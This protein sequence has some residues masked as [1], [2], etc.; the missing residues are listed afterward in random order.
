MAE[1]KRRKPRTAESSSAVGMDIRVPPHNLEMERALLCS[2][3]IDPDGFARV[4]DVVDPG[5]FYDRRHQLIFAA[6]SRLFTAA[7]PIDILTVSE[8]LAGGE[9]LDA[10]GGDPYLAGLANEVATSTHAEYYARVIQERSALRQLIASASRITA[11]AYE[12]PDSAELLDR[13]MRELFEIYASR[14]QGGFIQLREALKITHENLD[15]MHRHRD[16]KLTGVGTGFRSLDEYTSGF[17]RGDFIVIAG[18]PSMGKT[19]FS[20]DLARNTCLKYNV[21]VAFFSLEMASMAIA[22]RLIAAEARIDLHRLRSGRLPDPDWHKVSL[23]TGVLSEIPFFIDDTGTLGIMELRARAR[24]LKQQ[25]DIGI[26]FIDYLQL[27]KPPK[28]DSREQEVAQISRALKALARELDVPVVAVSQLSRAVEQRGGDKRPQLSDLRD[29]GAI[30]QDADVVIFIYRGSLYKSAEKEED[31]GAGSVDNTTEIII[32]KQRNGP[33]GTIKLYF[34]PE[35]TRFE[36][37]TEDE[38]VETAAGGVSGR[39]DEPVPF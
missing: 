10:A 6:M 24:R 9:E 28:A 12:A 33:T 30:E 14:Q 34:H 8:K 38:K 5:S 15:K 4:V 20:L 23:A 17:Q 37:L 13:A 36:A 39:E 18:R 27:M 29:S 22:M 31:D 7:S 11:E 21:P 26:V 35:Y 25:H 3:L 2:L 1:T 32:R 19:S 16:D